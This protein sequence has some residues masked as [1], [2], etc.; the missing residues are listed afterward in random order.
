MMRFPWI[1]NLGFDIWTPTLA[2]ASP[3]LHEDVAWDQVGRLALKIILRNLRNLCC[4]LGLSKTD[5]QGF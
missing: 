5:P 3:F 1:L 4:R 2:G